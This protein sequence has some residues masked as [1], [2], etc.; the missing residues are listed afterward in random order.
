[1]P[2]F[3]TQRQNTPS[4]N[5]HMVPN[6]G[7]GWHTGQGC[8]R[9]L[10]GLEKWPNRSL[11]KLKGKYKVLPLSNLFWVSPVLSERVS[12]DPQ[13]CLHTCVSLQFRIPPAGNFL[14]TED[15]W[16]FTY[17]VWAE[18]NATSLVK[19]TQLTKSIFLHTLPDIYTEATVKAQ[20]ELTA[21]VQTAN[22]DKPLRTGYSFSHDFTLPTPNPTSTQVLLPWSQDSFQALSLEK[23]GEKGKQG[24]D[25]VSDV[26][27]KIIASW[28]GDSGGHPSLMQHVLPWSKQLETETGNHISGAYLL[29]HLFAE[30]I[31]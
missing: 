1:M 4:A 18:T 5:L 28:S 9:N 23:V 30:Y 27:H 20:Q 8:Q 17:I 29:W 24:T 3:T 25:S 21:T 2:L 10:S 26:L 12:R 11:R 15:W 19:L 6:W 16:D 13:K 31:L 7:N 22:T 14:F